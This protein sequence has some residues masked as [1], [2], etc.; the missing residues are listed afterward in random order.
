MKSALAILVVFTQIVSFGQQLPP[1]PPSSQTPGTSIAAGH[2]EPSALLQSVENDKTA[3][4]K[5]KADIVP[6]HSL[7]DFISPY[8]APS[9]PALRLGPADRARSLVRNGAILFV[10]LGRRHTR[11]RKKSRCRSGSL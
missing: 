1:T 5:A 8:R 6:R 9:A 3:P 4:S 11:H 7:L 10:A 2:P